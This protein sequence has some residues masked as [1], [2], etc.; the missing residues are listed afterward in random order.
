[1]KIQRTMGSPPCNGFS[2]MAASRGAYTKSLMFLSTVL[3]MLSHS[4]G[5]ASLGHSANSNTKHTSHSLSAFCNLHFHC[6]CQ[7]P[8]A[9]IPL[10]PCSS[11]DCREVKWYKRFLAE[12]ALGSCKD[13]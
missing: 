5:S 2:R 8:N 9:R 7:D 1:M 11:I 3:L 4:D 13:H 6:C 12:I 10:K